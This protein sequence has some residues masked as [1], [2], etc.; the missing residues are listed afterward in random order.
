M[1]KSFASVVLTMI[2]LL[3]LG[4]G[5]R[6]EDEGKV[7]SN[8][9]FEFAVGGVTLPA[10]VYTLGKASPAENFGVVLLHSQDR[11]ALLLPI[12]F[13][14]ASAGRAQFDFEHV[15]DRYFL[16]KV[17]TPQGVYI[18]RTPRAITKVAQVKE[19]GTVTYSGG[20][21]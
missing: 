1:K 15:G 3:G 10:G 16:S 12:A 18:F 21:N 14:E 20:A 5:A 17:E 8:V 7:V 6:A 19:H 11:D 2:C 4:E 9:P 13:D